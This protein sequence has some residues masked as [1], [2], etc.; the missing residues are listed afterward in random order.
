LFVAMPIDYQRD[1]SRR[2]I[3]V[4]LTD[5][6]SL[7]DVLSVTDRQWAEDVW[8]YAVLYD[9]RRNYRVGPSNEIQQIVDHTHVVGGGRPRGPVGVAISPRPDI[10]KRGM[11]LTQ[12]AGPRRDV[13]ILL[14]DAQIEAWV[15]RNAP[16]RGP[17]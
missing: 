8:E 3:M 2:L 10:L 12:A 5:P 9:S 13:E 16:R 4:T 1:D 14:N 7:D 6:F 15:T 17:A 11:Q